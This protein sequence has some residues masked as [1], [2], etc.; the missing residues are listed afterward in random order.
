[1]GDSGLRFAGEVSHEEGLQT[2][3]KGGDGREPVF[4][5][6]SRLEMRQS[7]LGG[8]VGGG[9]GRRAQTGERRAEGGLSLGKSFPDPIRGGVAQAALEG[10]EGR[11]FIVGRGGPG[12]KCPQAVGAEKQAPDLVGHPDAEGSSA[13]GGPMAVTAEDA[14][15]AQSLVEL[16]FLIVAAQEA[17]LDQAS[18]LLAMGTRGDLELG[19]EGLDF[20]RRRADPATQDWHSPS[21][22]KMLPVARGTG[23]FVLRSCP[24][25]TTASREQF[26]NQG[27]VRGGL[28]CL[29]KRRGLRGA[30]GWLRGERLAKLAV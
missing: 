22:L 26:P 7:E 6:K 2:G 8:V 17:V 28:R 25:N 4:F 14:R 10:S 24:P 23:V 9:L 1:M 3:L 30:G 5:W 29:E 21:Q 18:H 27:E 16:V 19:V 12:Q 13:A 20:L 11:Q 15:G